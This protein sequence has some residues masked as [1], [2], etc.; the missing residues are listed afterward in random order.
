MFADPNA[1]QLE[2]LSPDAINYEIMN[3][4]QQIRGQESLYKILGEVK[5][6]LVWAYTNLITEKFL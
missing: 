4:I 2:V 1:V 3:V 5:N 6:M